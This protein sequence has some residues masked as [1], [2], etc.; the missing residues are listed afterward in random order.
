MRSEEIFDKMTDE[1]DEDKKLE[2]Y[3]QYWG[4]KFID[5]RPVD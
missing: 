4:Q 2:L 5:E 3:D 1:K